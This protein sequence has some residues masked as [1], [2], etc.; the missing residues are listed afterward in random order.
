MIVFTG[1]GKIAEAFSK[2]FPCMII[3]ARKETEDKLIGSIKKASVIIHNAALIYSDHIDDFITS[4]LDLT[5]RIV[6]LIEA[7]NPE[8]R[9]I[10]ISSMSFLKDEF[11]YQDMNDMS[12]YAFSK[13]ISEQYVIRKQLKNSC[14][15]RFSTLFYK[16]KSRDGLSHL[17]HRAATE[18]QVQIYNHGKASRDFIPLEIAM[19]YLYTV[20]NNSQ[21]QGNI[22]VAS[23][24]ATT[25]ADVVRILSEL[26]P[27]LLVTNKEAQTLSVLSKFSKKE[28]AKIS[29][30]EYELFDHIKEFYQECKS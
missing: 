18:S 8:V 24:K 19:D 1:S 29:S 16:D 6:R 11:H 30:L 2:K 5:K 14:N 13:A 25:F 15:V 21:L 20:A 10:N 28:T 26:N 17:I 4:N 7:H 27:E 12:P 22:N 9:F 3:S 23:G